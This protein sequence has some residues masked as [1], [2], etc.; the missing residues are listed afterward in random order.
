MKYEFKWAWELGL[1]ALIAAGTYVI[2]GVLATDP[3]TIA[4][5]RDLAVALVAGAGRVA[6]VTVAIG[7]AKVGAL[8]RPN[9]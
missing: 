7:L 1:A 6:L 2:Q 5:G 8:V 3:T 9:P 4:D